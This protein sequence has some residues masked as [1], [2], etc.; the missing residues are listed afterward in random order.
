MHP[1]PT[2]ETR[3]DPHLDAKAKIRGFENI[4]GR[5]HTA[6]PSQQWA[7]VLQTATIDIGT[8]RSIEPHLDA[9]TILS[10]A[11]LSPPDGD[12]FWGVYAAETS[13]C[14]LI[15]E[16]VDA[17]AFRL[18]GEKRWCSLAAELTHAIVTAH[19][20]QGRRAFALQLQEPSVVVSSE[21]WNSRGLHEIPSGSLQ[22]DNTPARPVGDPDWYLQ[23]PGFW[24]GA[25][26]VAAC[27][28]G[29][30]INMAR[31]AVTKHCNRPQSSNIGNL[32]L[33]QIDA[34]IYAGIS[35]LVH[36][37][38]LS[39]LPRTLPVDEVH[40]IALRVRNGIYRTAQ[41][42]QH[43]SK[44]L[45]G[46]EVLTQDE[47]FMKADADLTVYLSQHHGFRD[48]ADLGQRVMQRDH[49]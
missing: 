10:E 18:T 20:E 49:S 7:A 31:I 21:P 48:E 15:A 27:W 3:L 36:A 19:T 6:A 11:Q 45:A 13:K 47:R 46:P 5:L 42:I 22:C 4:F 1:S 35:M 30:A 38:S 39:E 33:G 9:L 26:R 32:M 16:E 12:T 43:L 8:A 25:I 24:W 37:A 2:E 34:E 28:L 41:M 23:R 17:D 40:N 44:E 14:H 29:G